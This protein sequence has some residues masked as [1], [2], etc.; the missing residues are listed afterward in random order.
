MFCCKLLDNSVLSVGFA[1]DICE[2]P[3]ACII[4]FTVCESRATALYGPFGY[5]VAPGQQKNCICLLSASFE[6]STLAGR[7]RVQEGM[8]FDCKLLDNIVLRVGIVQD[9]SEFPC[10]GIITSHSRQ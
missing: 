6:V 8:I 10:V 9:I 1:Q 7:W 2:F 3:F 5:P 4:N